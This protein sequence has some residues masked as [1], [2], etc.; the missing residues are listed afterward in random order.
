MLHIIRRQSYLIYP[1]F[2]G[3][4]FIFAISFGPGSSSCSQGKT[5]SWAARINGEPVRVRAFSNAY[6]QQVQYLRGLAKQSGITFDDAMAERMGLRNQVLD[7]LVESRLL[8]QAARE[9]QLQ[10]SDADLLRFLSRQ[11]G[12]ENVKFDQYQDWVTRAFETS[13]DKFEMESRDGIAASRL[14][15]M[16]AHLVSVGDGDLDEAYV[17]EHDRAKIRFAR[18]DP[19]PSQEAPPSAAAVDALLAAEMPAVE[20]AYQDNLAAYQTPERAQVRQILRRLPATADASVMAQEQ[21]LLVGLRQQLADG[22]DFA[23][24]ARIHSQDEATAARG[25]DMGEVQRG[26]LVPALEAVVFSLE[27]GAIGAEPVQ[28]PQ[29]LHL[30]QVQARLPA[31]TRP[32]LEVQR[33]VATDLGQ[34][35]AATAR[36]RAQAAVLLAA[37]RRGGTWAALTEDEQAPPAV[38][39]APAR[40]RAKAPV[41]APLPRRRDSAWIQRDTASLPRLGEAPA[42]RAAIFAQAQ[43][44]VLLPEIYAVGDSQVVVQLLQREHPDLQAMA[45]ERPALRQQAA[46]AKQNQVLHDWLS[47]LRKR[48]KVEVNPGLLAAASAADS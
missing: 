5:A 35:R 11:Y 9:L 27:A 42:L 40:G 8:A 1:I 41:Q 45:K 16:V 30:L 15:G 34:Q 10:V 25:G 7:Q 3:I 44:D 24:L 39:L 23:A 17:R 6:G 14:A 21:A 37:L 38:S 26:V 33:Q 46:A 32:L 28:T 29:G 4:I 12:V 19:E 48:A 47:F 43:G 22:A 20:S 13:V 18:F 36:S 2:G 31:T